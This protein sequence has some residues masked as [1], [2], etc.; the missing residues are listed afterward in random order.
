[1]IYIAWIGN[2]FILLI[3]LLNFVIALISEVYEKVMDQ[4]MRYEYIQKQELNDEC[5]R[6]YNF[7]NEFKSFKSRKADGIAQVIVING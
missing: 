3:V 2:Q 6:F 1:M 7:I 4:K 5:D